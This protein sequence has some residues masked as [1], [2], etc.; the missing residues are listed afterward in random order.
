MIPHMMKA[1]I[2]FIHTLL[3]NQSSFAAC[4]SADIPV[5]PVLLQ[6]K[7]SSEKKNERKEED[8]RSASFSF[9]KILII[10]QK[11]KEHA[12]YTLLEQS[13]RHTVQ[14]LPCVRGLESLQDKAFT[15]QC[16]VSLL[17][18]QE[19]WDLVIVCDEKEAANGWKEAFESR[20]IPVFAPSE[21]ALEKI[22]DKAG[23]CTFLKERSLPVADFR[24]FESGL[25]AQEFT[26]SHMAPFVFRELG[27]NGR[28]AIPYDAEET[29]EMLADWY[30]SGSISLMISE[31]HDVP[32]FNLPV[33]MWNE[34]IC[35]LKSLHVQRGE[36]DLEDDAQA[37][38]MGAFC[39]FDPDASLIQSA[40]DNVLQPLAG[41]LCKQNAG[42][43]GF[44]T[45]E[46]IS[47]PKGPVCVNIKP[48]LSETAG[49]SVLPLL[50]SDL[51]EAI[52]SVMDCK[53]P[54]LKWSGKTAL[55]IALAFEK[56]NEKPAPMQAKILIS[57][58]IEGQVYLNC[59]D[60][61]NL[62]EDGRILFLTCFG[63]SRTEAR[64]KALE[65]VQNIQ[66]DSLIYRHDIGTPLY[67]L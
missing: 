52:V 31:F 20:G 21:K 29:C 34:T 23:W 5:L 2:I 26:R 58:N 51:A 32:R 15:L 54:A 61:G 53:I 63:S 67:T 59:K 19:T 46:F 12:L 60:L 1:H 22:E 6:K 38:G 7:R 56:K 11:A 64:E 16:A 57:E 47:L 44:L 13:G 37:K 41:Y 30:K 65:Q 14:L 24:I 39:P 9:M 50:Q 43:T 55:S 25:Q 8:A 10:G 49:T 66:S 18:E 3:K 35:P 27:R 28:F 36:F 33:L 62:Q 48:G 45:A 40:M 42:Y 17:A 4:S